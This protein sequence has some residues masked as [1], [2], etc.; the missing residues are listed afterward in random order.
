[1]SI[2]QELRRVQMR[3]S[4]QQ[5]RRGQADAARERDKLKNKLRDQ[6]RGAS[7]MDPA[8]ARQLEAKGA[9][10][11]AGQP[12][13]TRRDLP[14]VIEKLR[15][16][17][18]LP[19]APDAPGRVGYV[20]TPEEIL[21]EDALPTPTT[22]AAPA[23]PDRDCPPAESVLE[24]SASPYAPGDL[25]P[26]ELA[27]IDRLNPRRAPPLAQSGRAMHTPPKRPQRR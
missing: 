1:M 14:D 23:S 19:S 10:V 11:R 2:A 7:V 22:P 17:G 13:A 20:P 9:A 8:F 18:K 4:E 25:T 21:G 27:E 15:I 16:E 12:A 3:K 6:R 5:I 26:E 24:M